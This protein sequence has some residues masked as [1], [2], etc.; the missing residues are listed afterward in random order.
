M[1]D[2]LLS[3]GPQWPLRKCS[4]LTG[5]AGIVVEVLALEPVGSPGSFVLP[6]P[7]WFCRYN[8][9]LFN[10]SVHFLFSKAGPQAL[11]SQCPSAFPSGSRNFQLF[12][13]P[14]S[15]Q[16]ELGWGRERLKSLFQAKHSMQSS[17][18][19]CSF[20]PHPHALCGD[21]PR[22]PG[23]EWGTDLFCFWHVLNLCGSLLLF[24]T[25]PSRWDVGGRA[26]AWASQPL[27]LSLQIPEGFVLPLS[28][29][30]RLP[31]CYVFL[32]PCPMGFVLDGIFLLPSDNESEVLVVREDSSL[33]REMPQKYCFKNSIFFTVRF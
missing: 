6:Q 23:E 15:S 16:G 17:L 8:V 31:F 26:L 21:C 22:A 27:P 28:V 9:H 1:L 2:P 7:C 19:C 29:F 24:S 33:R 3:S 5:S 10:V 32:R 13:G 14:H 30:Q 25:A 12:A 11:N 20:P 4:S 18:L